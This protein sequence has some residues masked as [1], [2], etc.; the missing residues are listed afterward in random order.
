MNSQDQ[1]PTVGAVRDYWNVHTLGLQYVGDPSIV[2]GTR[3][4]FDHIRPWMNPYKFPWIMQRIQREAA[5]LQGQRLLEI[6]CGLGYDSL[7]FLKRGVRVTA[8][9][10]TPQAVELTRRHFQLENVQADDVRVENSLALSFPDNSFDAVWAN[11][12]LHHTGNTQLALQEIWRVLKP[13]GRAIICHF[14]RRGSWMYVVSRL[15]RENIEFKEQ[16]PPVTD[17][18]TDREILDLFKDFQVIEAVY[19]HYRALPVA[20]H[21]LKAMLYR[22]LFQPVYN[23]IPERLAKPLAYKLSV[24]AVKP[25]TMGERPVPGA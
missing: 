4:F 1:A 23:S 6:G 17:F 15:G 3:E 18:H 12:V 25:P 20:R 24:T 5:P 8:T 7:E 19:D 13:G 16:D 2:P 11:G 14:Y 22:G 21:G 10:L 9:D